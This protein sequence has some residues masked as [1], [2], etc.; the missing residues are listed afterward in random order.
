[1]LG[2]STISLTVV[3]S[4]YIYKTDIQKEATKRT[5]GLLSP[6]NVGKPNR[7]VPQKVM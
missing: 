3:I 6:I 2:I 5:T 7:T 1:M 4:C